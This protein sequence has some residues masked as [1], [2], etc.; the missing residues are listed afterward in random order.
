MSNRY[1]EFV[2]TICRAVGA[3]PEDAGMM[4]SVADRVAHEYQPAQARVLSWRLSM[5]WRGLRWS[6]Y[7]PRRNRTMPAI[8]E[9]QC[10]DATRLDELE[11][12]L[13]TMATKHG[14]TLGNL[15][16]AKYRA[17]RVQLLC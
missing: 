16:E 6:G 11:A 2:E 15:E 5:T 12:A 14:E 3:D 7:T 8:A 10:R 13:E 9:K 4:L 1:G 17:T